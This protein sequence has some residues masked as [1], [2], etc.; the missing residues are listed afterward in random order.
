[1][2][3]PYTVKI[4]SDLHRHAKILTAFHGLSMNDFFSEALEIHI[5]KYL[6][7]DMKNRKEA[8]GVYRI[9]KGLDK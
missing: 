9:Q 1:M 5:D 4:D 6:D 3:K 7:E 2:R 8:R